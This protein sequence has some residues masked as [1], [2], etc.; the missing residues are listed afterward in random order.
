[1]AKLKE[2]GSNQT[3]TGYLV[4]FISGQE[5]KANSEE[6]EAVQVFTRQLVEDY[7]Y[8]KEHIQTRPQFRVKVRPSDTKKEYPVDIAVFPNSKK[9]ED[10]I[11]IIVECKN[12]TRKDGRT[13]LQD[14]LRF[15]N[16]YLGVWFN[17]N[18]RFFL[19]KIEKQ[20]RIEFEEIPN[21]PKYGQR[22]EDIGRFKQ[23]DLK[24][25]H[26]LKAIFKSIRNYLAANTVGATRDE[27]LAQQLINLIFCKLYDEKNTAPNDIIKFRAGL[28]E[29]P[30]EVE[31]RILGIFQ[32]V[33]TNLP[34]VID[35]DD[36]ILLDTNSII[37]VVGEL[38]NYS[39]MNSER[40]I[41]ADAFETF[42]GHALISSPNV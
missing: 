36:R 33:K 15:S 26:N 40:D 1:M 27:V 29:K 4:D 42:I 22:I 39:L 34:E 16:A 2:S 21:I 32:E 17:G 23:K 11:Y 13:Q 19:R 18:E 7:N 3:K 25:T 37:Y 12:K 41:I 6:I 8:P 20:G 10:E 5:V 24:P 30:E 14:Y 35:M 9:Q 31:S 28:N 38:Q